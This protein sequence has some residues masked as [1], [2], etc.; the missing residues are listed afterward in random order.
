MNKEKLD[1]ANY[2]SEQINRY[3]K[4]LEK[5]QLTSEELTIGI[6]GEAEP[7]VTITS[8][9]AKLSINLIHSENYLKIYEMIREDIKQTLEALKIRFKAL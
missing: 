5:F 2:L 4:I 3:E 1:I 7:I 9:E 6:R 8:E